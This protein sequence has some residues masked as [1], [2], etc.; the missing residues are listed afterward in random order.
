MAQPRSKIHQLHVG[1]IVI[2]LAFNGEVCTVEPTGTFWQ[3]EVWDSA[4][5]RHI[6]FDLYTGKTKDADF[7]PVVF[8]ASPDFIAA[9][10]VLTQAY[11]VTA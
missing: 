3:G 8:P 2:C 1:D 11:E 10:N 6:R 9:C 7:M 5:E 4:Q